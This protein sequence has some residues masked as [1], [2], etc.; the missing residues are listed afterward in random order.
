VG[1]LDAAAAP[2]LL[3]KYHGRA[4]L[5]TTGA[6]A[7]HCR[8]CFRRHFPYAEQNPGGTQWP[9]VLEH[10]DADATINEI[11][12]SGGDP[13]ALSDERLAA[14]AAALDAVPHLRTLRLHTR[15]PVVL[16]ERIDE[17]LLRWLRATR[18]K[19]VVVIHANHAREIDA[20]VVAALA[21]LRRAGAVLLNQTV[22]LKGVN[23]D[24]ETLAA[25]SEALFA[26]EVLPY[27]LN[28]LDR[29]AGAAHFEVEHGRARALIE[30]LRRRLP[31]YLVP[32]LVC[33][34]AGA[35]YKLPLS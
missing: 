24:A 33:E 17:A 9:R 4:L 2:G 19:A 31:G 20:D 28:A 15:L 30:T 18:L 22:L 13:L 27:Y 16:P 21:R 6:C 25:L 32:R 8:Y 7:V 3:R 12:L 5:V 1:D 11:I 23:D 35:P 34:T 14:L 26:A 10:L 29:V